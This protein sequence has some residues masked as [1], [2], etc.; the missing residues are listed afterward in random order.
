MKMGYPD[1]KKVGKMVYKMCKK[2]EQ[3]PHKIHVL[4]MGCGTGLIGQ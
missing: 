1:A 2:Y 4:D 3:N